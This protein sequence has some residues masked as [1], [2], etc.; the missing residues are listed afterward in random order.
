MLLPAQHVEQIGRRGW[1]TNLNVALLDVC[2]VRNVLHVDGTLVRVDQLQ[3]TFNTPRGVLRPL[4]ILS[5]WQVDD[6]TR[7]CIPLSLT[8]HN[9]II[10]HDL[11]SIR[12]ITELGLPDNQTLWIVE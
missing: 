3:R 12:K 5:M 8:T 11:C 1:L 10:N 9:A 4:T 2:F 7:K 6:H